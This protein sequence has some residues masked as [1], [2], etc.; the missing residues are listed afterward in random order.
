LVAALSAAGPVPMALAAD[1]PPAAPVDGDVKSAPDKL[2][3]KDADLLAEA[4]AEGAKHVTMMIATAPGK[5]EQVAEKLNPVKGRSVGHT[6]DKLGYVRPTV[7]T[8]KAD[9][10]LAAAATLSTVHG[11]H[12]RAEIPAT[13]PT[14]SAAPPQGPKGKGGKGAYKAPDKRTP[15]KN[16]YNPS[17]ETGA[18]DFVKHNR[19]ADGRGVTIGILDSGVDLAHPALQKTTTG[20]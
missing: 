17:F 15:A 14:P 6:Q 9:A 5:T 20:E 7:P 8:A 10:A 12:L 2:G 16:P 1:A 3:S 13:A 18:V 11:I 4:K 19:K